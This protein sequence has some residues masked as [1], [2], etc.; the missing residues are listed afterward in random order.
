MKG[1]LRVMA[2]IGEEQFGFMPG[3]NTIDVIFV[4][5]QLIEHYRDGQ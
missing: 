3:R 4:S 5:R 1:R 2:S